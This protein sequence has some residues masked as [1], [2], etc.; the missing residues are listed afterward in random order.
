MLPGN[1]DCKPRPVLLP[2]KVAIMKR[3]ARRSSGP[4]FIRLQSDALPIFRLSA[5]Q[6]AVIVF[7]IA[8]LLVVIEMG[9]IPV[10]IALLAARIQP[11]AIHADVL[12]GLRVRTI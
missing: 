2:A 1:P 4:S 8:A 10:A 5:A 7:N 12:A 6:L 11:V 9:V 3:K